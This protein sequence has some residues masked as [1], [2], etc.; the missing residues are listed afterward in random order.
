M[1]FVKIYTVLLFIGVLLFSCSKKEE[2]EEII[3]PT[4][5]FSFQ[6]TSD[7][8]LST[9]KAYYF[10]INEEDSVIKEGVLENGKT[11]TS[12]FPEIE[13]LN[14]AYIIGTYDENKKNFKGHQFLDVATDNV[15]TLHKYLHQEQNPIVNKQGVGEATVNF[16]CAANTSGTNYSIL[17]DD[18]YNFHIARQPNILS[19]A[20]VTLYSPSAEVMLL[21]TDKYRPTRTEEFSYATQTIQVGETYSLDCNTPAF[22][23]SRGMMK[24]FDI[25]LS[26]AHQLNRYFGSV[27]LNVYPTNKE[28]MNNAHLYSPYMDH[29]LGKI[30]R[31]SVGSNETSCKLW[32]PSEWIE[33]KRE[34]LEVFISVQDNNYSGPNFKPT[35]YWQKHEGNYPPPIDLGFSI[36]L[37]SLDIEEK[38]SIYTSYQSG[39]PYLAEIIY[40]NIIENSSDYEKYNWIVS[41]SAK[42]PK[43]S[44]K[45]PFFSVKSNEY[46]EIR[47]RTFDGIDIQPTHKRFQVKDEQ[48][49]EGYIKDRFS[50]PAPLIYEDM[51]TWTTTTYIQEQI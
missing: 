4:T 26:K 36:P 35:N 18:N 5:K 30:Y 7:F 17:S 47:Y 49:Y 11:Y 42:K 28:I 38:D 3:E 23:T 43:V 34:H 21:R 24:D 10:I 22:K 16:I 40:S 41:F 50:T 29:Y 46:L 20:K 13:E 44:W 8:L 19:N 48:T 45:L 2:V 14:F 37:Y 9:Q 32:Y 15:M 12:E 33:G 31:T 51:N 1:Q 6:T 39:E 27:L 25:D